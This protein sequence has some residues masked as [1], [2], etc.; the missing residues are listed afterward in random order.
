MEKS[1]ELAQLSDRELL[2]LLCSTDDDEMVYSLFTKRYWPDIEKECSKICKKRKIDPHIGTEIAHETFE[3]VRKYK[4]FNEDQIKLADDRKAVLVY[5]IRIA[6]RLFNNYHTKKN[7]EDIVHRTY[8]DEIVCAVNENIDVKDLKSKKDLSLDIL[9]KLNYKEQRILLTDLEY[10]RHQ[11]Y[12]PD[13]VLDSLALEL[14]VKRETIRK[15]R[16][17]AIVK[18]NKAI[19]EINQN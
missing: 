2:R 18:I 5:L 7:K 6:V 8:F 9:K 3:R 19:D 16:E 4:S 17:R 12:L 13:D 11:K 10:K 14:N 15:I 1:F